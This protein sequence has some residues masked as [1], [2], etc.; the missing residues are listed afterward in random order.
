MHVKGIDVELVRVLRIFVSRQYC[1][2]L[3]FLSEVA[4]PYNSWFGWGVWFCLIANS[5]SPCRF[6]MHTVYWELEK[7]EGEQHDEKLVISSCSSCA[8]LTNSSRTR[9]STEMRVPVSCKNFGRLVGTSVYSHRFKRTSRCWVTTENSRQTLPKQY[10]LLQCE[11][12]KTV[13]FVP[14]L[15]VPVWSRIDLICA[16]DALFF[17]IMS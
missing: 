9:L 12:D 17:L 2:V 5:D 14:M 4:C 6:H 10:I 15:F 7:Y 13:L 8:K 1:L 16:K 11:R 3:I